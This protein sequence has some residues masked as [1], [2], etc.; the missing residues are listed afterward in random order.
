MSE[1]IVLN[2]EDARLAWVAV[3]PEVERALD[4]DPM[5]SV[6]AEELETLVFSGHARVLLAFD[7][8][9]TIQCAAVVQL[10]ELPNA[11][12]VIHVTTTA[13]RA[14][15]EWLASLIDKFQQL[16]REEGC[17]AVTMAGRPGW[18]K[19]LPAYGFRTTQIQMVLPVE[20]AAKA[21]GE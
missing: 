1:C 3:R 6:D 4:H 12:R 8:D 10:M 18:A 14:R 11:D 13:G 5:Q 16:A 19:V 15:D 17:T 9:G 20:S 7:D 21:M 2:T